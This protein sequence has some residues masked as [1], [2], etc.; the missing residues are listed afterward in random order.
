M[1]RVGILAFLMIVV[2]A[3]G[4]ISSGML[5][6]PLSGLLI[7]QSSEPNASPF[8][9]TPQQ[10][11]QIVFW[12]GFVIFNV[13]GLALTLALIFWFLNRSLVRERGGR[14]AASA[15]TEIEAASE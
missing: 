12:G 10:A 4:V 14:P 2:I 3:G 5:S 8:V 7:V 6:D 15:S 13:L 1:K 11:M 9:A